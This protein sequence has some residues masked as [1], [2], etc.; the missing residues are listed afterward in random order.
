[1]THPGWLPVL[2][3]QSIYFSAVALD[4]LPIDSVFPC[5]DMMHQ[6]EGRPG[7]NIWETTVNNFLTVYLT[8]FCNEVQSSKLCSQC[9]QEILQSFLLIFRSQTYKQ[10]LPC[11]LHICAYCMIY[12]IERFSHNRVTHIWYSRA[13]HYACMSRSDAR[14]PVQQF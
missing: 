14:Q 4:L 8:T 2:S 10:R 6:P 1:M 12:R 3:S 9:K 7:I 11:I 13:I 5:H